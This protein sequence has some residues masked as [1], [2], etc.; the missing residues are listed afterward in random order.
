M[1]PR[2]VLVIGA[3]IGGLTAAI[4]LRNAGLDVTVLEK[5]AGPGGRCGRLVR[6]GHRFDTGPTLLVMPRVYEA[7]FGAL[8]ASLHE[9][10]SLS[11]VDPTYR[12][13]FDDGSQLA[14]TSDMASMQEQLESI[15][16]GKLPRLSALPQRRVGGTTS[17]IVDKM[18]NRDFRRP[19]DFFTL[20]T[21]SLALPCQSAG[22]PLPQHG[23]LL[24]C[25]AA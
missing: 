16:A 21:L 13:V 20:Q 19:Q 1:T 3:G 10:L 24:R 15:E 8:G 14:L 18:V 22:E 2:S 5:N 11:R 17:S 25:A 4:H 12:L 6:D 23:G 9:R 7:E